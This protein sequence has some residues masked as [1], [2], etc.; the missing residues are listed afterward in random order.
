MTQYFSAFLG[1]NKRFLAL[2]CLAGILLH[3]A[4]GACAAARSDLYQ[5]MSPLLDRTE[6]GYTAAFQTAFKTV[7]VRVTG[8][9]NAD[10][11]PAL[12]ALVGE[13][14]RFVQQYHPTP[15]GQLWIAFDGAAI[16]RWLTQHAQPVWGRERPTTLVL[17]AA[18][19]TA[20]TGIVV[21]RDDSS[22]LKLLLDAQ[23]AARGIQ[24]LWPSSA[25]LQSNHLDFAALNTM[26]SA[27]LAEIA[28]RLGGDGILIGHASNA[29]GAASMRWTH[30]FADRN[31]DFAGTLEG[32]DRAA[33]T[34]A[35]LFA[36]SGSFAPVDIEVEGINDVKDYAG[37]QSFLE[38]LAFIT[39]VSIE[40]FD[41]DTARF[42]L[43]MRGGV[44]PLNRAIALSG[45]LMPLAAGDNG[46]QRFRLHR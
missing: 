27:S 36:T 9:R 32:V 17:L 16:E 2:V 31:S 5:A 26:P 15:D 39:H 21:T 19:T 3:G 34:Y 7:L 28:H 11:D 46:L 20:L 38:S 4:T 1:L 45:L 12:A 29:T 14:R 40:A 23:A 8:L 35:G 18:Q 13:A 24:L 10:A 25:D 22:E 37:V 33:D 44:E 43:T 42:R 30:V 41:G 6:G